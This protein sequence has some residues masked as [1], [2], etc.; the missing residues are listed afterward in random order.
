MLPYFPLSVSCFTNVTGFIF[1]INPFTLVSDFEMISCENNTILEGW[2]HI[3]EL[4]K[5]SVAS[6]VFN[7][8]D[9]VQP[10]ALTQRTSQLV[11][12]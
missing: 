7:I 9:V 10:K 12:T 1:K 6:V 4:S 8:W 2:P 3:F 5:G 11:S